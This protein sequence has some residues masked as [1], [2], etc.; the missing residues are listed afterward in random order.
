MAFNY[1]I[2]LSCNSSTYFNVKLE[3]TLIVGKTYDLIID[4]GSNGCYT[5][6]EGTESPIAFN[7]TIYN[8]PWNS[9]LECSQDITP[10]PTSSMTPTPTKTPTGTPIAATPT[11]TGTA[12]VTP[13]PTGTAAVTPTPTGTPQSTP[14]NTPTPSPTLGFVTYVNQQYE[15]SAD[16]LGSFSG[17][18]LPPNSSVPYQVMTSEDGNQVVVQLNAISLGGFQGLNN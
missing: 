3:D 18:T 17:G 14:T 6:G 10:T 5:I 12:A 7:A 1:Y 16:I 11:P 2:A 15:Y 9:C 8:G 4:G 13:T